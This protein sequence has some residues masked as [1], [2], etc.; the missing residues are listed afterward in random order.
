M[1]KFKFFATLALLVLLCTKSWSLDFTVNIQKT[2]I[3]SGYIVPLKAGASLQFEINV[4]NNRTDTCTVSIDKDL[5]GIPG[6]WVTIDN[7]S[8][9]L[10]PQQSTNFL[11]TLAIPANTAEGE[12]A[13]FLYF[14]AYDKSNS[15]HSFT[16]TTQT[17]TVDKFGAFDPFILRFANKH[18]NICFIMEQ[19]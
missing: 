3:C 10:F 2:D 11:L 1:K 16:Y 5:M 19:L 8:Q 7:N 17:V 4:K 14:N 9:V 12:Y 6:S 18:N 13:M 15:N